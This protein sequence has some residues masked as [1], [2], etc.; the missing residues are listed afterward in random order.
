M[1]WVLSAALGSLVLAFWIGPAIR[2]VAAEH[3]LRTVGD[4]LEFRFGVA[5]RT[6]IA[7]LLWVGR[8]SSSPASSSPCRGF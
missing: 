1:W 7:A 4:Y 6:T 2:R 3:D 5:V 8:C